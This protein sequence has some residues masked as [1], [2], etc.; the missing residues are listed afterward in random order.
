[1]REC[2]MSYPKAA[3]VKDLCAKVMDNTIKIHKM[4][5]LSNDEIINELIQV[6]GIGVWTVH[7]FLIFCMGRLNVLP[8]GDLGIK[9]AVR[10]TYGLRKI[11]T[12]KRIKEISKRNNWA[13]YESVA[14]WYLWRSLE[15][16]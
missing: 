11:P 15:N 12:E 10:K 16:K 5:K 7:M 13:P 2:G 8:V 4:N 3:F 1:M 9:N 6:K 14:S